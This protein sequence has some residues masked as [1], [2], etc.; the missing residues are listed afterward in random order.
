MI[1]NLRAQLASEDNTEMVYISFSLS[2]HLDREIQVQI[3]APDE[4]SRWMVTLNADSAGNYTFDPLSMGEGIPLPKGEYRLVVMSD[5][6]RRV[7]ESF[8]LYVR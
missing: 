6:G 8:P 4:R 2:E 1:L 7:E 3:D 5:D